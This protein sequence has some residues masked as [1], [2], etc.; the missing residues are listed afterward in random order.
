MEPSTNMTGTTRHGSVGPVV[1][2][3]IIVLLVVIGGLYFWGEYA[4]RQAAMNAARAEAEAI[5]N[6]EDQKR[7]RLEAQ[8]SSD[9]ASAIEADLSATDLNNL[10]DGTSQAEAELQ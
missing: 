10:D 3:A 5:A 6:Q 9:A 2:F 7:D 8:S 1:A 4:K